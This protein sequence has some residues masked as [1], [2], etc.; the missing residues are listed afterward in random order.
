MVN[1]DVVAAKLTDLAF[2]VGRARAHAKASSAELAADADALDLV[3]FNLM[4]AVQ[5][6]ADIASHVIADSGW[7]IARTLAEGFARL[8]EHGVLTQATAQALGRA[9]G[10]RNVVAHGYANV[11]VKLVHAAATSGLGELDTFARELADW[12]SRQG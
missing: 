2:R 7:P 8:Q 10:L 6:C 3:A 4:L 11:D 12:L 9:A 1:R 5:I